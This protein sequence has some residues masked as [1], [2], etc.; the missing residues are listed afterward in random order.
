MSI[1]PVT[2][3]APALLRDTHPQLGRYTLLHRFASGG[4]ANVYAARINTP[5]H[6]SRLVAVKVMHPHLAQDPEFVEMFIDEAHLAARVTHPNVVQ[7]IELGK[8]RGKHFIAMEYIWGQSVL[9]ILQR[10]RLPLSTSVQIVAQA[11]LG[12]HAAHELRDRRGRLLNLVHRDIS[13]DN[14]LVGYDGSVKVADFG[15]AWACDKKHKTRAGTVKGKF[16]YMSPE[17]ARG[18]PL[19]R[20]S[21]VFALGVV[22]YEMTVGRRMHNETSDAQVLQAVVRCDIPRPSSRVPGYPEQLEKLLF[23]A[24]QRN[25]DDRYPTALAFYEAL[26]AY[27]NQLGE[28][29][30]PAS[31]GNTMRAMF[32][33]RI[34]DSQKTL[35]NMLGEQSRRAPRG[36]SA[37]APPAANRTAN[38]TASLRAGL[39][40]SNRINR[41]GWA[42]S[43]MGLLLVLVL[44]TPGFLLGAVALA[45]NARPGGQP[46]PGDF[47]GMAPPSGHHQGDE[48]GPASPGKHRPGAKVPPARGDDDRPASPADLPRHSA[49]PNAERPPRADPPPNAPPPA[50]KRPRWADPPPNAPPPAAK[51]P[52]WADPP[53]ASPPAAKRPPARS[54]DKLPR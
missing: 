16:A 39:T 25:P 5:H 30:T 11:A 4:M 20:R 23:G 44:L 45:P 26:E 7:I 33:D 27:L 9:A 34:E 41:P 53:H 19:D 14:I 2:T 32:R 52:P 31:L 36:G 43:V 46:A 17:Q 24:L 8:V 37:D 51:R 49:P 18:R 42:S 3:A 22:L 13:P 21:D 48:P 15:V 1:A 12:L 6:G 10:A 40:A 54:A 38:L 29:V 35:R 50:T 47:A 28:R